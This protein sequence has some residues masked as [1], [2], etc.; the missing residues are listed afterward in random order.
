MSGKFLLDTN[1]VIALWA[2]DATVIAQLAI[3]DDH[4]R[5]VDGLTIVAW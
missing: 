5:H 2:K 3:A 4:F 1:I